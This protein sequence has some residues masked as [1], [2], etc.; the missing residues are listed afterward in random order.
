MVQSNPIDKSENN[1]VLMIYFLCSYIWTVSFSLVTWMT[2][3]L[4]ITHISKVDSGIYI[5]KPESF[6]GKQ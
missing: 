6:V 3:Q 4:I 5:L 1:K 2:L